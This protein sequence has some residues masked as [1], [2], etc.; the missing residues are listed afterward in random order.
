MEKATKGKA[1]KESAKAKTLNPLVEI[2]YTYLMACLVIHC[3]I[4]M[5]AADYCPIDK[6]FFVEMFERST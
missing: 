2:P 4:L 5:S 3:P 1:A 6:P